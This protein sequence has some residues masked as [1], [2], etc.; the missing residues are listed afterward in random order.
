MHPS[1][2]LSMVVHTP[3]LSHSQNKGTFSAPLLH[4]SVVMFVHMSGWIPVAV[5]VKVPFDSVEAYYRQLRVSVSV[6]VC[7]AGFV[8]V[9]VDICTFYCFLDTGFDVNVLTVVVR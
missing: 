3:S 5:A 4:M 9:S 7:W 8:D 6:D 1:S 2:L